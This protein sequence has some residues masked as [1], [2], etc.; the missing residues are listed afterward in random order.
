LSRVAAIM[1]LC[2][3][4]FLPACRT[5]P[6]QA[7]IELRK[8]VDCAT[9]EQDIALIEKEKASVAKR[10]VDGVTAVTP[11]GAVL[12][13]ITHQ[14]DEKLEVA[15]GVYNHRLTEKIREIKMTCEQ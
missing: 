1:L 2:T 3:G 5:I 4:I 9:A 11:A 8:P 7:E 14:E 12:G 10:F 15:I 13:L 6:E